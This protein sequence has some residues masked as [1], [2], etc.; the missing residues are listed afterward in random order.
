MRSFEEPVTQDSG[1][2]THPAFAVLNL[3]YGRSSTPTTLFGSSIPTRK[4]VTLTVSSG[5]YTEDGTIMAGREMLAVELTGSQLASLITNPNQMVSTPATLT[6]TRGD[7]LIPGISSTTGDKLSSN[8]RRVVE[9]LG[10]MKETILQKLAL[11]EEKPTKANI[12]SLRGATEYLEKN[13]E[14]CLTSL[15]EEAASVLDRLNID[16]TILK[17]RGI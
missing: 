7:G 3:S 1:E 9:A 5:Y 2:T 4:T 8:A 16:A 13:T 11:V 6:F 15:Q 14:Y 12:R 17:D 10:T